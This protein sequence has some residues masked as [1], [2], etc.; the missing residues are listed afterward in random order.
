LRSIDGSSVVGRKCT[1]PVPATPL[2][3]GTGLGEGFARLLANP[4]TSEKNLCRANAIDTSISSYAGA[5]TT[6][7]LRWPVLRVSFPLLPR[8]RPPCLPNHRSGGHHERL[9]RRHHVP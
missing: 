6:K 9:G 5:T 4:V 2:P 3:R 1:A 7:T 8:N